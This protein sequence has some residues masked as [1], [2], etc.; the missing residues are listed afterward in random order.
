KSSPVS[1]WRTIH[2]VEHSS[3]RYDVWVCRRL[4]QDWVAHDH[5]QDIFVTERL[6]TSA[7]NGLYSSTLELSSSASS[8]PEEPP[9]GGPK[10]SSQQ[11]SLRLFF[12]PSTNSA[13]LPPVRARA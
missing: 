5:Q 4:G 9:M 2:N 12:S 1:G 8:S 13:G 11:P 6:W 3:R 7:A 10:S